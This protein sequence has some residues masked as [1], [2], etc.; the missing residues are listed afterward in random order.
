MNNDM[1]ILQAAKT[2]TLFFS[3]GDLLNLVLLFL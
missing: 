2:E 1:Q 3:T